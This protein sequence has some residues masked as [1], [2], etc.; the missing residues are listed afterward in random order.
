MIMTGLVRHVKRAPPEFTEK[1][2]AE[3]AHVSGL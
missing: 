3:I 1:L 2:L